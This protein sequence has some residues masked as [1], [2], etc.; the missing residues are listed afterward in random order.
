MLMSFASSRAIALYSSA[1]TVSVKRDKHA[2]ARAAA[3]WLCVVYSPHATL[4][5]PISKSV[6]KS[7]SGL[8]A[9]R[10]TTCL[11]STF[12]L[13]RWPSLRYPQTK[14]PISF[15]V[16]SVGLLHRFVLCNGFTG[17]G[18]LRQPFKQVR[19][20]RFVCFHFL[21]KR[22][23]AVAIVNSISYCSCNAGHLSFC[24]DIICFYC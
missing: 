8:S 1:V 24:L 2:V 15:A 14:P 16:V 4:P 11:Y 18:R 20:G 17:H 13:S 23:G 22:C 10:Q 19:P 9:S 7:P 6:K 21:A 3:V 5:I 12:C